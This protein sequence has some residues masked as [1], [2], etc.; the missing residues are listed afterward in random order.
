MIKLATY[1]H[2][3]KQTKGVVAIFHGMCLHSGL[4]AIL[5][6]RLANEGFTAVALDLMG[7]GKS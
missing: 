2:E 7:H 1:R 3:A 5:A 4:S 6:E